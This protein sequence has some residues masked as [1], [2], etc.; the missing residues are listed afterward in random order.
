VAAASKV[1]ENKSGGS[2]QGGVRAVHDAAKHGTSLI[3]VKVIQ[4]HSDS[5]EHSA[6]EQSQ[7]AVCCML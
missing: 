3:V 7:R 2:A 1:I 4:E 5:Q 6:S